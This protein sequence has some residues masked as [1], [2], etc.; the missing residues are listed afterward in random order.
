MATGKSSQVV[1]GIFQL[2]QSAEHVALMMGCLVLKLI[3]GPLVFKA[4]S[5]N[6]G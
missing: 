2:G 1:R 4:F 3:K 6:G 5:L